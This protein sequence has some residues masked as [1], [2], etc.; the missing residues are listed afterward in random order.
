MLDNKTLSNN[1]CHNNLEQR[2]NEGCS[3]HAG[4]DLSAAERAYREVLEW[5][6]DYVNAWIS[7]GIVLNGLGRQIEAEESLRKAVSIDPENYYSVIH[8]GNV[9][10]AQGRFQE[11]SDYYRQAVLLN[12]E[13]VEAHNNLGTSFVLLNQHAQAVEQF[14]QALRLD[15]GYLSAAEGLSISLV[16]CGSYKEAVQAFDLVCR[17]RPGDT[18][19]RLSLANA[20]LGARQYDRARMEYELLLRANPDFAEAKGGLAATLAARGQFSKPRAL[21]D[22]ALAG[23]SFSEHNWIFGRYAYFLLRAGEF[24]KGWDYYEYRWLDDSSNRAL[25]R[26][27]EQPKWNGEP[28][29]GTALLIVSEQGLGDEI[30]FSSIFKEFIQETDHCIIECDERL[31]PLFSRSFPTATIVGVDRKQ[32]EWCQVLEQNIHRLPPFDYWTAIGTLPRF[33]RRAASEFPKHGGYLVANPDDVECW[34]SRLDELG[35]GL[36]IGISW[37]GGTARTNSET[38]SLSLQQLIPILAVKGAQFVSLQYGDCGD[39]IEA[40]NSA[41]GITIHQMPE[42]G[43][44]Y[45]QTAALVCAL[46]LVISVCTAIVHLGGALGRPVWVMAPYVAEWRY[47]WEGS[48]MIWYPSVRVHRQPKLDAWAPVIADVKRALIKQMRETLSVS[49]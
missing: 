34:K 37:R 29:K 28:L 31:Q 21:F 2:F 7:L 20:C 36:K 19:V 26:R 32:Q 8:L 24:A 13:S 1:S 9:V 39:E 12:S 14:R 18:F 6:P 17:L 41:T 44:D 27:I 49:R 25:Q 15:P 46:D 43:D 4:G 5:R 33:R 42:A 48:S 45:D 16:A 3:Y 35:A 10:C 22:E 47:G 23:L 38:R 30:M 40:L 11:A